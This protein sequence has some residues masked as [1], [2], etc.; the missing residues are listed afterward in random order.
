MTGSGGGGSSPSPPRCE[1][2][3]FQ[4]RDP[5]RTPNLV[6][7]TRRLRLET[8]VNNKVSHRGEGVIRVGNFESG[9]RVQQV[10]YRNNCVVC[11]W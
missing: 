6:E 11:R 9:K 5:A 10:H 2:K 4:P 7:I 1:V 3:T 8:V